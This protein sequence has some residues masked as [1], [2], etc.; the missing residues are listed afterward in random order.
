MKPF[1]KGVEI[2]DILIQ[3][4]VFLTKNLNIKNNNSFK[5][6]F[7]KMFLIILLDSILYTNWNVTIR[8]SIKVLTNIL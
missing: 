3:H 6:P 2:Q 4:S 5:N 8:I 1:Q 7:F